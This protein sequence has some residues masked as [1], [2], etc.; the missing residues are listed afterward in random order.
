[1]GANLMRTSCSWDCL[2]ERVLSKPFQHAQTGKRILA[3]LNIN[4][5]AVSP[6]CVGF[7]WQVHC[8]LFPARRP[9]YQGMVDL[10]D[11]PV[12]KLDIQGAVC[13]GIAS[14]NNHPA[15]PTIQAVD[16]P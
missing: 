1:M 2:K 3:M 13:F 9:T 16:D 11:M 10:G 8:L 4:S 6:V 15:G 14:Q 7:Q 12:G 5:R